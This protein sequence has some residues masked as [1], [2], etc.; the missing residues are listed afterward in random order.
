MPAK[1]TVT[2]EPASHLDLV[3]DLIDRTFA[4]CDLTTGRAANAEQFVA[5]LDEHGLR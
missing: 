5:L 3:L 4:E 1:N 2:T